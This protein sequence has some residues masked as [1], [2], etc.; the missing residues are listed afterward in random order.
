MRF[1][2]AASINGGPQMRVEADIIWPGPDGFGA[3]SLDIMGQ[4]CED[5]YFAQEQVQVELFTLYETYTGMAMPTS[6]TKPD[7]L[8]PPTT[9]TL[10][11][12]GDLTEVERHG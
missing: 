1:P 3:W 10:T 9:L 12:N 5:I 8:S 7:D 11:G 6:L 4:G 2:A